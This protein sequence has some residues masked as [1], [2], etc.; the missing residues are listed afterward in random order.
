M[1]FAQKRP[2]DVNAM[3]ELK[4]ISDPQISPDGVW[5][6]FTVQ[7]VDVPNNRKLQQIWTA[8]M[9]GGAPRQITHEGN[10]NDRPRW[11]PDSHRI[12]FISDRGGSS[13]I[14]TMDPDGGKTY[15]VTNFA[16]EADG[17]LYSPDGK[18]LL[19]TSEVYPECGAED[20]CNKKNIDAD[21]ASKTRARVYTELLYRHW[22]AWQ[23]RRR[24]HLLVIPASGGIIK[25]LTP[26][27]RD[28]PPF[29]LGGPDDYDISPDGKE[30]CYSMISDPVPAT[31][32]NSDLYVV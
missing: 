5:V 24:S 20:A 13:Q 23:S 15:Q 4:R 9:S 2:F 11:S 16:A 32:T 18:N 19:F 3:M 1:A 30:V 8:P 22:T 25:D 10:M 31:S 17:V 21:A 14:W 29:S 6:A 7:S 12:A 26:G 28:V 27:P